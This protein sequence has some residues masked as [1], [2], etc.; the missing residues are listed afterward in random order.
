ML[1][2]NVEQTKRNKRSYSYLYPIED[3]VQGNF[4]RG[5]YVCIKLKNF[6]GTFLTRSWLLVNWNLTKINLDLT[7]N[8]VGIN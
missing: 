2:T 4:Q 7:K 8:Q 3:L 6:L 5:F 1:K